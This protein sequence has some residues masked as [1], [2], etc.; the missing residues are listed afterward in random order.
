MVAFARVPLRSSTKISQAIMTVQRRR[1]STTT[2]TKKEG[3]ISSV[4]VS[5]SNGPAPEL[6]ARF[7]D[8]K[9]KLLKGGPEKIQASWGRLLKALKEETDLI[10]RH[11]SAIIPSIQF[12]DLQKNIPEFQLELKRRGVAVVRNVV[13]KEVA[14]GYKDEVEKYVKAN[15]QTT[16][17]FPIL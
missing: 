14:R 3:D 11:G 4:F 13:P 17:K 10:N 15:P 2:R 1:A 12:L 8:I 7:A 5:L 6:P 16:G 9:A